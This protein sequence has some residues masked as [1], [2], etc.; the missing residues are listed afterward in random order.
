MPET[1]EAYLHLHIPLSKAMGVRVIRAD[2]ERVV[3]RAPLEPNINHFASA[4]GG[5]VSAIAVLAAW[6][7]IHVQLREVDAANLVIQRSTMNFL[8]PIAGEFEAIC[9]GEDTD[10]FMRALARKGSGRIEIPAAVTYQGEV[11]AT[12][13]GT[14]VAKTLPE[15]P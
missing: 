14:F 5:S 8:K 3:L 10:A 7:W 6:S 9:D 11:A 1:L 13:L 15:L 2:R 12:L 4:F